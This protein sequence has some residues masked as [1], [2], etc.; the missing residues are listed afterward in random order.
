MAL[1]IGNDAYRAEAELHNAAR[2]ADLVGAAFRRIG[3]AVTVRHN[4]D[5]AALRAALRQFEDDSAGAEVAAIYFAGHGVS[6]DGRNW[7]LPIDAQLA[8]PQ[9]LQDEAVP[10]TRLLAS[11]EGAGTL[12]LVILDACRENPFAS[13]LARAATT[14]SVTARGLSPVA[15]N[16]LTTNR[17][18]AYSAREGQVAQ[19]GV[20]GGNS[21]FAMALS[22][23]LQEPGLEI[24]LLFRRVRDDVVSATRSSPLGTQEP[25]TTSNLGGREI[26]LVAASPSRPSEPAVALPSPVDEAFWLTQSA[27][28]RAADLETYLAQF[29][30]GNFADEAR[31]RLTGMR[32][33]ISG[34][35]AAAAD[36]YPV[37]IGQ[38]F[39]DCPACPELVV[40]PSGRFVMGSPVGEEG[41][42]PDE[43]P[44]RE[45]QVR[46]PLA[47]A[48]L[49]VTFAEWDACV[50]DRMC[51]HRPTDEGWGRGSRPVIN[52]SWADTQ[53]FV[54]WLTRRSG[55]VYRLLTEAEWE[56]AARA[57]SQAAF[58]YGPTLAPDQANFGHRLGRTTPTG[59][60]AANPWGLYDM[61]GNVWEWV[62]DCWTES[63]RAAPGDASVRSSP[64]QCA[65]RV[66]RGGSWRN[67][68]GLLRSAARNRMDGNMRTDFVGFRVVGLP[69]R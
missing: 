20:R 59:S 1:V 64:L 27:S 40:L 42:D 10:D 22:R 57:G 28:G 55:R 46:S 21:P 39:R 41:R 38:R 61:M 48:V 19:D 62:S 53:V 18:F 31:R 6:V 69:T 3:F 30:T 11:V 65:Q 33:T 63:Y 50:A 7:L 8:R 13:R 23:R 67:E 52:V 17:I 35:V 2:D 68:R 36:G 60:Y 15:E 29:P 5:H 12:Q 37:A 16:E 24:G 14:R 66:M 32:P 43:G 47:I 58:P 4:L 56:Y 25:W 34:S 54:A 9:R 49:E 44:Q 26:Y 51:T 45:V